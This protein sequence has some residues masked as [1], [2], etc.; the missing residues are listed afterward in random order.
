MSAFFNLA[1]LFL[2]LVSWI[3][4]L[5]S[6]MRKKNCFLSGCGSFLCCAIALL[7]Q[8][9]EVNNRVNLGDLAAVMDTIGAVVPAGAVMLTVSVGLNL[10]SYVRSRK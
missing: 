6:V 5:L 3:I 8:L 10:L 1:S 7:L 9:M 4:P 2:G